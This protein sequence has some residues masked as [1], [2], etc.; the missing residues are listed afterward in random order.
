MGLEALTGLTNA[1]LRRMIRE[2]DQIQWPDPEK[3]PLTYLSVRYSVPE[4]LC[5][6]LIDSL[7]METAEKLIGYKPQERV[8]TIRMNG[9]RCT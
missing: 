3:E 1:G 9:L 4:P 2:K 5:R 6:L 8:V 7:G